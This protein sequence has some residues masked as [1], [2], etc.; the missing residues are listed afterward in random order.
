MAQ[1]LVFI[2]WEN[3][4]F[5]MI[6]S[7]F[8]IA[9]RV[10]SRYSIYTLVNV[11]GLAIGIASSLVIFL[12]VRNELSYDEFHE[13]HDSIYRVVVDGTGNDDNLKHAL[14]PAP[15]AG[16]IMREVK[17]VEQVVRVARFGAWVIS[18]NDKQFNEDGMIFADPSFF[19]LFSFGLIEGNP[20]S[21]LYHPKSIVLTEKAAEKYFG[22][23]D[24]LGMMLR[25]EN[26]TTF[27]KVT[28]IMENVPPNSHMHFDFVAS[29][30]TYPEIAGQDVWVTNFLYTYLLAGE[31][32]Q[33][34]NLNLAL[35]SISARYAR[36]AYSS[37][38]ED[39]IQSSVAFTLQPLKDIHLRSSLQSEFEGNGNI[40][41]VY[42]FSALAVILLA[43][44]CLN[45]INLSTARVSN[46]AKEIRIRK[47]AGSGTRALVPQ[48]LT[49]SF[50][51]A[52]I[53]MVLGL[54]IAELVLPGINRFL[55]LELMLSQLVNKWGLLLIIVL[56]ASIG[57]ISGMYPALY[58]SSFDP[59]KIMKPRNGRKAG[60][61]MLREALLLFQFFIATGAI[62]MTIIIFRQYNFMVSKD[63]GVNTDNM[64]IIRRSDGLRDKL[65]QYKRVS[66]SN[67][68]VQA[69]TNSTI[70]PGIN[71]FPSVPFRIEESENNKSL[72]MDYM[73]ASETFATTY[74]I[75]VVEGRFFDPVSFPDDTM[76]CVINKTAGDLLG[77]DSIVGK[78]L[79]AIGAQ[80]NHTFKV[81]G[82]IQ[83]VLFETVDNPVGPLAMMLMPGNYEGYLSVRLNPGDQE[84]V[85]HFLRDEWMKL[86]SAYPFVSFYLQKSLQDNYSSVKE[87]ARIFYIISVTALIIA[88]L[89]FY[90]FVSYRYSRYRYEIGIHKLL[91]A[92]IKD[93]LLLHLRYLIT[94]VLIA[95]IFA[96]AGAYF[97][98]KTWM[99]DFHEHIYLNP[100]YFVSASILL[101]IV[102]VISSIYQSYSAARINPGVALKYE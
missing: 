21:V 55:G 47:I 80:K 40:L 35:D 93:I 91:G 79:T 3:T 15:L 84:S 101:V 74:G 33:P 94:L 75:Q 82:I 30:T 89:G 27:Y 58:L 50:L 28:G 24:P 11:F 18:Y 48:F 102:L 72:S 64:L 6:A 8:K 36:P 38:M 65:D 62:I 19:N 60:R 54:L 41:Y 73:Y 90:S 70:I 14:T 32:L 61:D 56:M 45:F 26:D 85:V 51:M 17:G 13:N 97:L 1:T 39:G 76:A 71:A 59:L 10:F 44:S 31:N 37:L 77:G 12:Y 42:L 98:A 49:E 4:F 53:A 96:W 92:G 68:G 86:T 9:F 83:D 88:S 7:F 2:T 87:T 63:L 95:S 23:E 66:L 20:D 16:S 25:V 52:A 34:D 99:Q 67:S 22:P 5:K 81:I 46:R 57:L 78:N 69:I 29:M 43:V 100:V